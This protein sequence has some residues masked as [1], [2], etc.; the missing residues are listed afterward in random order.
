MTHGA[1]VRLIQPPP[2]PHLQG[3]AAV[4][5]EVRASAADSYG[6]GRK[7]TMLFKEFMQQLRGGATNLYLSTQ[8]V[9]AVAAGPA[10]LSGGRPHH[11]VHVLS[12]PQ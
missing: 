12:Y 9:G 3:D 5:V 8:E 11:R 7:Q 1:A 6:Q 10:K 2:P 4:E